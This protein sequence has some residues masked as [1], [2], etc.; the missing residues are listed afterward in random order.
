MKMLCPVCN[1]QGILQVRGSSK[2]IV[3]YSWVNGKRIFTYHK[4]DTA[5]D[6]EN[7]NADIFSKM[8]SGPRV[9][10]TPDLWLVKP[11]S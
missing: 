9:T 8:N 10:R 7:A 5:M 11:T 2:R 3:H 1:V 4:M 6:T